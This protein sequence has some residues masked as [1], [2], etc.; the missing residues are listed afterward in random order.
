MFFD[1]EILHLEFYPRMI[2]SQMV[3]RCSSPLSPLHPPPKA[4]L[5]QNNKY[6]LIKLKNKETHRHGIKK[7]SVS[8]TRELKSNM[9]SW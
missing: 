3:N 4:M 2:F 5:I 8:I 9:K 7:S 6:M 1:P